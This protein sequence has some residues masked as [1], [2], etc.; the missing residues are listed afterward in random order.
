MVRRVY[1]PL[2]SLSLILVLGLGNEDVVAQE[3]SA[4]GMGTYTY[5]ERFKK[6]NLSSYQNLAKEN[7]IKSAWKR[8]VASMPQ[9]K[10]LV[11]QPVESEFTRDLS[12]YVVNTEILDQS[13]DKNTKTVEVMVR[14][15]INSAAVDIALNMNSA[16]Q[17]VAGEGSMFSFV[18]IAREVSSQKSFADKVTT[19][20]QSKK[21]SLA[22]EEAVVNGG[23]ITASESSSSFSKNVTGGST[24]RK[25]DK[26]NYVVASAQ[27]IDASMGEVLASAGYEVI[28]YGD[29]VSACGGAEP[30]DIRA[31]F[32][33]SDD[34]SRQTRQ[35]AI[36]GARDC[37]IAYF[38]TGTI[39]I[40]LNDTDPVSGNQRVYVSVRG[41]VWDIR[42]RLP[43][44]V[45]SVG[46]VQFSG[47][48]AGQAV[49]KR[50]AL[51]L[52]AKQAGESLVSQMN[53]KGLY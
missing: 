53:A 48:G 52:A 23:S 51:I 25:A 39:D 13:H 50:N 27:D 33:Q 49:A 34:M 4:K 10:Q 45:A 30:D 35:F 11:Y 36:A 32:S 40:G 18:F 47:L 14:I 9:A 24:E 8:F 26:V 28:D 43:K 7:A 37:E 41:Q 29:V 12:R 21:E 46:P 31:E 44:K 20:E 3:V 2:L 16:V 1:T 15:S 6:K 42:K 5:E 19:I 22:S 38:A 17:K